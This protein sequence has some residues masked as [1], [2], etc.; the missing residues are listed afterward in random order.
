MKTFDF[1]TYVIAEEKN[2]GRLV[3]NSTPFQA[4]FYTPSKPGFMEFGTI[5]ECQIIEAFEKI[6]WLEHLWEMHDRKDK[7]DLPFFMVENRKNRNGVVVSAVD[8]KEWHILYVR[9]KLVKR[10]LGLFEIKNNDYMTEVKGQ[11]QEDV[12]MCL[13]A[14]ATNNLK[15]LDEKIQ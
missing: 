12:R 7:D 15:F 3:G 5:D 10:F 1:G 13:K 8:G 4:I 2:R 11:S 14:L 9:P 6:P